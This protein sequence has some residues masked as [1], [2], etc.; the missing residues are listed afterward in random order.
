MQFR[1]SI[2][3]WYTFQGKEKKGNTLKE[4]KKKN[5]TLDLKIAFFSVK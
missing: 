3:F 4:Q 1:L 5:L 2:T